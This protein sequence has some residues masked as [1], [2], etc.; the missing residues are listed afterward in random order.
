MFYKNDWHLIKIG[1]YNKNIGSQKLVY[2][3]FPKN[4][5]PSMSGGKNKHNHANELKI[6]DLHI[7]QNSKIT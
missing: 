2:I 4:C 5:L 3:I 1:M 6:F 7:V